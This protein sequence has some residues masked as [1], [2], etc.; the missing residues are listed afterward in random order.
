MDSPTFMMPLS[1][2]C[3]V[4]AGSNAPP[5]PAP[6]PGVSS[7]SLVPLHDIPSPVASRSPRGTVR[8]LTDARNRVRKARRADP[9]CGVV[10]RR[11]LRD[12]EVR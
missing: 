6:L 5:K 10:I 1:L 4:S 8:G 2:I 11:C 12:A 7:A 3:A 9:R